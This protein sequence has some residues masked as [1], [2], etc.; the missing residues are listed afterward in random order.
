MYTN[1][2]PM[3]KVIEPLSGKNLLFLRLETQSKNNKIQNRLKKKPRISISKGINSLTCWN[4]V[5]RIYSVSETLLK[6]LTFENVD[7][8]NL[9]LLLWLFRVAC[10]LKVLF[11]FYLVTTRVAFFSFFFSSC[12]YSSTNRIKLESRKKIQFLRMKT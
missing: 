7:L 12:L 1:M 11:C 2:K 5:R 6:N 8:S 9:T 4:N 10:R 3:L